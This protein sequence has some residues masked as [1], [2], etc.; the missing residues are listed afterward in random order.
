M[1]F[2]LQCLH[3]EALLSIFFDPPALLQRKMLE[4]SVLT[5]QSATTLIP[6]RMQHAHCLSPLLHVYLLLFQNVFYV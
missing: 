4:L 2:F 5:Q 3:L 1:S 6:K